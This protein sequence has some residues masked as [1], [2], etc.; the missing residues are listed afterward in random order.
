MEHITPEATTTPASTSTETIPEFTISK[1]P[2]SGRATNLFDKF[3]VLGYE[4]EEIESIL[5]DLVDEGGQDFIKKQ[6][7]NEKHKQAMVP[8]FEIELTEYNI[9]IINEICNSYDKEY[10]ENDLIIEIVF[11]NK[12]KAFGYKGTIDSKKNPIGTSNVIFSLNP[13][14]NNN[15]KSSSNGFGL[16]FYEKISKGNI[17]FFFPKMFL[18]LSEFPFF[19][20][21]H[22][23]L[24][25][26]YSVWLNDNLIP[27]EM[28]IY[29]LIKYTPSPLNNRV[30]LAM[31]KVLNLQEQQDKFKEEFEKAN[32]KSI[33]KSDQKNIQTKSPDFITFNQVSG[34]PIM[35]FNISTI[36]TLLPLETI[37]QVFIFT[38]LENDILIYSENLELLNL[39][40]YLF[41]NLSY[42]INDSIYFWHILSVSIDTFMNGSSNFLGKPCST[43]IGINSKYDPKVKTI[44]RIKEHFVLDID[45][46]EFFHVSKEGVPE[47]ETNSFLSDAISDICSKTLTNK[48]KGE[49]AQC[50]EDLNE[51]L[52]LLYKKI[53]ILVHEYVNNPTENPDFFKCD[54]NIQ[55]QNLKIQK[56]FY[57]FIVD[58][59]KLFYNNFTV[60]STN[61]ENVADTTD[62]QLVMDNKIIR[63]SNVKGFYIEYNT[64]TPD[65]CEFETLFI[66]KFKQ[67]SKF[68]NYLINFILFYD[69]IDLFKIPLIFTEELINRVRLKTLTPK[70]IDIF[71]LIDNFYC[72][73]TDKDLF[74]IGDNQIIVKNYELIHFNDFYDYFEKVHKKDYMKHQLR[75]DNYVKHQAGRTVS[76]RYKKYELDN[77]YLM[78]YYYLISNMTND[79]FLNV[80]PLITKYKGN[81]IH[82]CRQSLISDVIEQSLFALKSFKRIE[83]II[84]SMVSMISAT[85]T[86]N[87]A[88][89]AIIDARI[90]SKIFTIPE[91][92]LRKYLMKVLVVY[93]RL[94]LQA[95]KEKREQDVSAYVTCFN[96]LK[97]STK[98]QQI[99]PN[100]EFMA[101]INSEIFDRK[102]MLDYNTNY[103]KDES[104]A[105]P[106]EE[107]PFMERMTPEF[108]ILSN[109]IGLNKN[110]PTISEETLLLLSN[111]LEYTGDILVDEEKIKIQC[112]IKEKSNIPSM[113]IYFFSLKKLFNASTETVN[114]FLQKLSLD[115]I[116]KYQFL[117]IIWNV[118]YHVH[119]FKKE[120]PNNP[121]DP[122]NELH[123]QREQILDSVC[124]L[125]LNIYEI[126]TK[127]EADRKEMVLEM[128]EIKDKSS[129][130]SVTVCHQTLSKK[131]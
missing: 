66:E 108:E 25:K 94:I 63:S 129:R 90:I 39:V 125:L 92:N 21:F 74:K 58:I 34:Y 64:D 32:K 88:E 127:P 102:D 95:S 67:S 50:I 24:H 7:K 8:D 17:T 10:V 69:A 62:N 44:S 73:Q 99:L 100:E 4:S 80:F 60:N 55:A 16:L 82:Q 128:P 98:K 117:G 14:D 18:I 79:E 49:L 61:E 118:I 40:M 12:P 53:D 116:N 26:L 33:K 37:I 2:Y 110:K 5:T 76:C 1:Y 11:P 19:T 114:N 42:P 68:G 89:N 120:F 48:Y 56:I 31:F 122:D 70:H 86:I 112:S 51:Q 85:R 97:K 83:F 29:N 96:I 38:F 9:T 22:D 107:T 13:Q 52:Q 93:A 130:R 35:D 126:L 81:V 109:E 47:A 131:K 28:I 87:K 75:S 57:S 106:I 41:A 72:I 59:Y 3:L 123:I 27:F 84:F 30:E 71:S 111:N 78:S 6:N 54:S 91:I 43:M 36:F 124:E 105:N 46:K 103:S 121:K 45:N 104:D 113:K 23:L 101:L 15:S 115:N 77:E 20:G 65:G 119:L